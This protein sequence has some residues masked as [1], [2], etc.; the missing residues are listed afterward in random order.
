ML[1]IWLKSNKEIIDIVGLFTIKH[2]GY[3]LK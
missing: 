2:Q 1:L 3:K